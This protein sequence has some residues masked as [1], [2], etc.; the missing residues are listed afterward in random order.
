MLVKVI[1][2]LLGHWNQ[3]HIVQNTNGRMV[4]KCHSHKSFKWQGLIFKNQANLRKE[5]NVLLKSRITLSHN[6]TEL[7]TKGY[8]LFTLHFQTTGMVLIIDSALSF[9]VLK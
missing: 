7:L 4:K 6:K 2:A 8:S 9:V 5:T 1:L 3:V